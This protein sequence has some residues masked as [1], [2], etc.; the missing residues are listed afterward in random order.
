MQFVAHTVAR[1]PEALLW[2]DRTGRVTRVREVQPAM[3][4]TSQR[5]TI[6]ASRVAGL[7]C[8][9]CQVAVH[10]AVAVTVC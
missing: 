9:K 8:V 2:M 1:L 6:G 7:G 5:T 10:V 4:A 3:V